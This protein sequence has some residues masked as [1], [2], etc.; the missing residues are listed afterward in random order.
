MTSAAGANEMVQNLVVTLTSAINLYDEITQREREEEVEEL[1]AEVDRLQKLRLAEAQADARHTSELDQQIVRLEKRNHELVN[2]NKALAAESDARAQEIRRLGTLREAERDMRIKA[3]DVLDDVVP[4]LQGE[5][6]A[7]RVMNEQLVNQ[8][9]EANQKVTELNY[10]IKQLH[11][12]SDERAAEI[13]RLEKLRTTEIDTHGKL[14]GKLRQEVARLQ[15]ELERSVQTLTAENARLRQ[16][17]AAVPPS[18]LLAFE[19]HVLLKN[20]ALAAQNS[21]EAEYGD[22]EDGPEK[23]YRELGRHVDALATW[24]Q[25]HPDYQ[26]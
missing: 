5:L 15:G 22:E 26:S 12:Q 6:D 1:R 7:A 17:L 18:G 14:E 19:E 4:R 25:N 11:Q 13:D 3:A 16:A 10:A 21:V 9:K 2:D 23:A 20:V 24:H 8:G